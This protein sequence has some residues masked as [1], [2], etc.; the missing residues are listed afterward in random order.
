[1]CLSLTRGLRPCAACSVSR[2]GPLSADG[3][4]GAEHVIDVDPVSLD[5]HTEQSIACRRTW[6]TRGLGG[7]RLRQ[8]A[9]TPTARRQHAQHLPEAVAFA[10]HEFIVGA[11][12]DNRQRAG[13]RLH[14]P[15]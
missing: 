6:P 8:Q 7:A 14:A 1:M 3:L 12:L 2:T 11:L 4:R 15:R 10:A 9:I 5:A 13:K